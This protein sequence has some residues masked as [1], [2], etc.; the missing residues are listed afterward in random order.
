MGSGGPYAEDNLSGV[1]L[2]VFYEIYLFISTLFHVVPQMFDPARYWDPY[3]G[4]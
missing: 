2:S 3:L 1:A 4:L